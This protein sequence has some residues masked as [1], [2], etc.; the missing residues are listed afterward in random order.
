MG[1]DEESV[2]GRMTGTIRGVSIHLWC[3]Y[4]LD[5]TD[6]QSRRDVS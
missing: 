6:V 1:F 4:F 5:R 3:E 2:Y